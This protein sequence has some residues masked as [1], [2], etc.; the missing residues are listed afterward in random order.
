MA[1]D[2]TTARA[3]DAANALLR[4]GVLDPRHQEH[5]ELREQ[6]LGDDALFCAVRDRLAAVGFELVQELGHMGVRLSR[7]SELG[8]VIEPRNHLG[9]D[10]SHIRVIVY[11]WVQ[12]VY[13]QRKALR[14]EVGEPQGYTHFELDLDPGA[15]SEG[16]QVAW[17]E[18]ESAFAEIYGK[19]MLRGIITGLKRARFVTQEGKAGPLEAGPALYVLVDG[20]RMEEFVV[21]LARRGQLELPVDGGGGED[22]GP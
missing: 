8:A 9:L 12:L 3:R 17:G 4:E 14:R 1:D 20:L 2:A 10:A 7:A 19:A 18:L 16:F 22:G 11:L 6:L 5:A 15:A 21:G 13:R